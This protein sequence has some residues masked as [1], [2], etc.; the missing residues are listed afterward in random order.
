M[1]K[2]KEKVNR[3]TPLTTMTSPSLQSMDG[4]IP[5][6]FRSR[7]SDWKHVNGLLTYK[8]RIYI[9]PDS[10]LRRTIVQ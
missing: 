7:L 5:P 8:D 3:N 10:S 2:A 4:S 6:A 9:P 1:R